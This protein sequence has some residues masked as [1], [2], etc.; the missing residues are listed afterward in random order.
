MKVARIMMS[1]SSASSS[2]AIAA[3]AASPPPTSIIKLLGPSY[4]RAF[5]C[6][7]ML[8]ELHGVV[9]CT[10]DERVRPQSRAARQRSG[11]GK[12][13]ILLHY[14]RDDAGDA[15]AEPLVL[16]ESLAINTYLGDAFSGNLSNDTTLFR[17]ESA[18]AAAAAAA[19]DAAADGTYDDSPAHHPH[20]LHMPGFGTL[21]RTKYDQLVC[22]I[23]SE[24][25]AAALWVHHKHTSPDLSKVFGHIPQLTEPC[26][27]NFAR[28]NRE[29]AQL[30]RPYLLGPR[31]TPVDIAYVHCLEWAIRERWN[32]NNNNSTN[33]NSN[34][35]SEQQE[36]EWPADLLDP[37]LALCRDRPAYRRAQQIRKASLMELTR[38]K[39]GASSASPKASASASKL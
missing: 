17:S 34:S 30:C 20:P 28:A 2:S 7:W 12:V 22:C 24:L 35:G 18:A 14:R 13:P 19:A 16:T 33:T 27:R 3:S 32:D 15:G 8:E 21:E 31:F 23:L 4:T 11:A 10:L 26:R 37:Y 5:R 1:A 6:L 39:L 9:A 38:K 36:E 29:L 25:D